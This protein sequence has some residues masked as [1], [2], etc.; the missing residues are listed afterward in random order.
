LDVQKAIDEGRSGELRP[1]YVLVGTETFLL[2][3][4]GGALRKAAVASGVPGFNEDILDGQ[5]LRGAQVASL[6]GTL[7]MMADTRFVLVR[8]VDQMA[9]AEQGELSAYLAA[10]NPSTCLVLTATKLAANTKL[11]KAAKKAKARF[12]AKALKAAGARKFV[13]AEADARGHAMAGDAAEMLVESLGEDLAALDDAVE[14]LS[15]YVGAGQRIDAAAVTACVTRARV[16]SIWALVDAISMKDAP[17]AIASVTSLL[18]DRE[19]PLRIL[20]MITRQLRIVAKM[21]QALAGGDRPADAVK[22]AGAPPFKA[23]ALTQAAK[24]FT[25]RELETAFDALATLDVML[26]GG[27][28]QPSDVLLQQVVLRLCR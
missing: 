6:A 2:E 13:T 9:L 3:R 5:G 23:R 25:M 21:R 4:A 24:R 17:V 28:K 16:D 26:K 15:L 7:P 22:K 8:R 27:S 11:G 18:Q 12:D 20:P 19:H 10:P 1:V 14:R